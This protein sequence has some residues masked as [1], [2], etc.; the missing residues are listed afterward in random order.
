REARG[1]TEA[2]IH[3]YLPFIRNFLEDRFGDGAVTLSR[4]CARDVV[5]FV[6]RQAQRLRI[7][8]AK[9]LTSA[10]RSFLQY[11]RY[12]GDV[13]LDL[14]AAVPTVANWSMSSIPRAISADQVCRLLASID[15]HTPMGR[16]DYAILLL[17][18]DYNDC[19]QR[20]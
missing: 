18:G 6:Q 16:R 3:L 9:L 13:K 15:R 12:R 11:A 5:R 8:R 14:S 1:L 20:F 4:L 7:K 2:T 19:G 17:L 10:L